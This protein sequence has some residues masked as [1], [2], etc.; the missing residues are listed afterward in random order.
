MLRSIQ[1]F[2]AIRAKRVSEIF[3][4]CKFKNNTHRSQPDHLYSLL[5][6]LEHIPIANHPAHMSETSELLNCGLLSESAGINTETRALLA[7]EN[8]SEVIKYTEDTLMLQQ[9][10][11]SDSIYFTISGLFHA[12]SHANQQTPQRLLG[13]IEPGEFIGEISFFDSA[14]HACASVKAM[15][16]AIVLKINRDNY[17]A[18]CKSHPAQ[19]LELTS[20]V[21]TGLARRLRDANE[22]VL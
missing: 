1:H 10:Q 9:G 14:A 21:A 5:L 16:N 18:L 6:H 15:K 8:F 13:R 20:A 2:L 7:S 19:A 12:V 3:P 22:K 4:Y 17:K 11:E